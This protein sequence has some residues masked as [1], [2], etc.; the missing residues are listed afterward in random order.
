MEVKGSEQELRLGRVQA[1]YLMLVTFH[2]L[3]KACLQIAEP[4]SVEI[5]FHD[6]K[7][8]NRQGRSEDD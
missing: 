5:Q 2:P 4:I 6:R 8:M 1:T 7:L 3:D